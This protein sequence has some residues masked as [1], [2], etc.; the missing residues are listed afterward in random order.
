MYYRVMFFFITLFLSACASKQTLFERLQEMPATAAGSSESILFNVDT[1]R[2]IGGSNVRRLTRHV[3]YPSGHDSTEQAFEVDFSDSNNDRY[4]RRINGWFEADVSGE[5]EFWLSADDSAEIWLSSD[6]KPENRR[7]VALVNKPSGYKVWDRYRSQKSS[8]IDLKAG[9]RYFI[10]I[11]HKENKGS[12]Y[13]TVSWKGPNIALRTLSADNLVG[14]QIEGVEQGGY[15]LGFHTGYQAGRNLVDYSKG[16]ANIDTDNDGLPDFYEVLIGSNINEAEDAS[17]DF[18]YDLL[19]NLDEYRLLT[20][21]RNKDTDGDG[22]DDGFEFTYGLS[23]TDERDGLLDLDGDGASNYLEF[24]E[25]T[26][27]DD[28]ASYP[29]TP[30]ALL[31]YTIEWIKPLAREDGSVLSSTE[32]D[33]YV[34]YSGYS[35]SE[36]SPLTV[37][38]DPSAERFIVETLE[39]GIHY[40]AI[41]TVSQEGIESAM[42]P[43]LSIEVN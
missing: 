3:R 18:D 30:V 40:F 26:L 29:E 20:N 37:V 17:Y 43:I 6:Q 41:S 10:E 4:A 39:E 36:L 25:G 14:Y 21:P 33:S 8:P 34:I 38:S 5:H 2:N 31:N 11:L 32:I 13:L 15:E 9:Q 27:P 1:W 35:K 12:D 22:M 19:S 7:L 23:A 28:A 24:L 16:F 42:S